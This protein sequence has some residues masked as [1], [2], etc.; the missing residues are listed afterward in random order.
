LHFFFS[1]HLK[2]FDLKNNPSRIFPITSRLCPWEQ[3]SQKFVP[4]PNSPHLPGAAR[5]VSQ[6]GDLTHFPLPPTRANPSPHKEAPFPAITSS[7]SAPT[8]AV[9]VA[10]RFSRRTLRDCRQGLFDRNSALRLC[11]LFSLMYPG[12]EAVSAVRPPYAHEQC[13]AGPN[14]TLRSPAG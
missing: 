10:P 1:T 4:P 8:W 3:S 5:D 7:G 6:Y 13:R 11:F 14:C 2:H 12:L 9:P